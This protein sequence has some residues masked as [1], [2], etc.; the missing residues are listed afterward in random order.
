LKEE[1]HKALRYSFLLLKYRERSNREMET[2]L[3]RKKFSSSVIEEVIQYLKKNS[4]I[5]DKR[6]ALK[7]AEEKFSHGFGKK[8]ISFQ[9]RRL[10]IEPS[11]IEEAIAQVEEKIDTQK[12]LKELIARLK[13]KKTKEKIF[14]YLFEH[15][16]SYSQIEKAYE[17][18][19]D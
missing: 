9:L 6:F 16:F 18:S 17:D 3:R 7:Y 11:L 14:R 4:L 12:I 1:F 5:D 2:R 15:G 10:G 13:K 8:V 19:Q